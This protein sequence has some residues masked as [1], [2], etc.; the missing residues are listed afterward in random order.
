EKIYHYCVPFQSTDPAPKDTFVSSQTLNS[1]YTP[2]YKN[3]VRVFTQKG[4]TIENIMVAN[5]IPFN[6]MTTEKKNGW[7]KMVAFLL[8]R[9]NYN[10]EVSGKNGA[11]M[12]GKM[13]AEGW[14][15][16]MVHNEI[17][18][19]YV[20]QAKLIKQMNNLKFNFDN[21]AE[22]FRDLGMFLSGEF[23]NVAPGAHQSCK[24]FIQQRSIP[25]I[26]Q[27]NYQ[28]KNNYCPED[29]CSA[30]TYTLD[31]FC[32]KAHCDNNTDNWTLIGFIPIEKGGLIATDGFDVKGGEFVLRDSRVFIDFKNINGVVLLVLKTSKYTH[33][34]NPSKSISGLYTR[35][36]FSCQ[37]S[38]KMCSSIEK[39]MNGEYE[40]KGMNFGNLFEYVI[41]A[42]N[43]SKIK[44][45][46]KK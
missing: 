22:G 43:K 7:Q 19:R 32:N 40:G 36:A 26:T 16:A 12:S 37:V 23:K 33:Q 13:Y 35:F 46:N 21:E 11:L 27:L 5:F 10:S 24:E 4:K 9:Q 8:H 20:N 25:S 14:R 41:K 31:D 15:K 29:F 1:F 18:G 44:I 28:E 2:L 45:Q 6:Q 17:V 34:T 38:K 39:Y 30:I 42:K 3:K